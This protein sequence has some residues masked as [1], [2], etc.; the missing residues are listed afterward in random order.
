MLSAGFV[1][2]E[3]LEYLPQFPSKQSL[4]P[5]SANRD[6][7]FA[8]PIRNNTAMSDMQSERLVGK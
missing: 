7:I 1:I 2:V 5:L 8:H 3:W 6:C 4:T